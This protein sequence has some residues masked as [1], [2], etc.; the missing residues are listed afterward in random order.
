MKINQYVKENFHLLEE[1]ETVCGS[2]VRIFIPKKGMGKIPD[3]FK[4][5][6]YEYYSN[7]FV[8]NNRW[9]KGNCDMGIYDAV[10]V[11]HL[12]KTC[13]EVYICGIIRKPWTEEES[14]QYELYFT[15]SINYRLSTVFDNHSNEK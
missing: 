15:K 11:T 12:S 14:N 7:D 13:V 6:I 2:M 8:S 5:Y 10:Y 9:T 4:D 1:K 3:S